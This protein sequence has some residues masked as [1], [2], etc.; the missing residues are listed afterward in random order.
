MASAANKLGKIFYL[1]NNVFSTLNNNR[2]KIQKIQP[3]INGINL[4]SILP[5]L[6]KAILNF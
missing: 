5:N 3:K 1:N 2:L 6:I 4:I